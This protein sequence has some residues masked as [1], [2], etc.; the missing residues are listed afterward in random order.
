MLRQGSQALRHCPSVRPLGSG[1]SVRAEVRI[2]AASNVKLEDCVKAG[3]FRQDLY[4]RLNVFP[5]TIPPLRDHP[6]DIPDLAHHFVIDRDLGTSHALDAG[7]H[8][9]LV[10]RSMKNR[11][12][13]DRPLLESAQA[14]WAARGQFQ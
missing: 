11:L 13:H 14:P 8:G 7:A 9:L 2:V 12:A 5:I 10:Q 1:R 4:Y 3:K 6:E